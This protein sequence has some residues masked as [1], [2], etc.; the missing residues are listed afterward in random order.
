MFLQTQGLLCKTGFDSQA[1]GPRCLLG[2]RRGLGAL[3]GRKRGLGNSGTKPGTELA[4][5]V[6]RPGQIGQGWDASEG[7]GPYVSGQPLF[8]R[9]HPGYFWPPLTVGPALSRIRQ[10]L[11]DLQAVMVVRWFPKYLFR[12]EVGKMWSPGHRIQEEGR[13]KR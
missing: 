12:N 6:D 3:F 7:S 1:G 10:V 2:G 9:A 5:A 8:S 13:K 4:G 11:W